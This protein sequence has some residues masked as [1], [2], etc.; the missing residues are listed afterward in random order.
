MAK[1]FVDMQADPFIRTVDMDET[2]IGSIQFPTV[3]LCSR[4]EYD[5]WNVPR[6]LLN[7]VDL[8]CL[9]DNGCPDPFSSWNQNLLG[10]PVAEEWLFD[11]GQAP[12]NRDSL[13]K[14]LSDF[15]DRLKRIQR[16]GMQALEVSGYSQRTSS[17][18]GAI[19]DTSFG[20]HC[21]ISFIFQF[22]C[23]LFQK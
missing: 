11:F 5:R 20:L 6:M 14:E 23:Y 18:S 4:Q 15:E 12:E 8:G 19:T 7:Q 2:P 13:L 9:V 16:Y 1:T 17:D 10:K 3:T 22:I 21:E